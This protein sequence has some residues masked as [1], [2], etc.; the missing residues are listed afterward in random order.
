M[1]NLAKSLTAIF[2]LATLMGPG[3]GIYLVNPYAETTILGIPVLY[4]W[5]AFWFFIQAGVILVA[6]KRIWESNDEPNT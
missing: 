3:P 6:S 4:A 1:S 5:V 2:I